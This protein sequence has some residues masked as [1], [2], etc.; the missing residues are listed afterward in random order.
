MLDTGK[1]FSGFSVNDVESAKKFYGETLGLSVSEEHGMLTLPV[2]NGVLV[3]PKGA[4]HAPATYTVPE[5]P[6]RG[7]RPGG[8]RADG[9]GCGGSSV[10]TG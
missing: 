5:L 1:A 2:G 10:T 4:A 3:Y 9:A 7:H 6:R 8:G